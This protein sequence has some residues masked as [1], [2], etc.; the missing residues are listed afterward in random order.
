MRE[1]WRY[2][3]GFLGGWTL[4]VVAA[5]LAALAAAGQL[6][7]LR[8]ATRIGRLEKIDRL[9]GSRLTGEVR[10]LRG[11][12]SQRADR[13]GGLRTQVAEIAVDLDAP[14]ENAQTIL[15]STAENRLWLRRGRQSVFSAVV[16]TGKGTTLEIEGRKMVFDTPTGRFKILSKEENPVW[17]P[18]DWHYVEEARKKNLEVVRAKPGDVIDADTGA[19]VTREAGG[20]WA[21]VGQGSAPRRVLEVR[22]DSIVEVRPDGSEQEIAPREF[23]R[24]GK[25]LVVPPLGTRQRRLEKTLGKYRLNLGDGYAIHGTQATGQLGRSVSH[26]CVRVGDEDLEKLYALAKVGDEVIIY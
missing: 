18:P 5:G 9:L 20:V 6:A 3:V 21:L 4:A 26:G 14:S 25:S 12:A 17:V 7:N 1:I 22:K 15:V 8:D 13:I 19:A 10:T 2:R 23:L 11:E 16:S 24:A